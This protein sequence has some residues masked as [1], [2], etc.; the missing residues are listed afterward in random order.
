MCDT[1]ETQLVLKAA[2]GDRAALGQLLERYQ[3]RLY[4]V[5]LR[6]VYHRN[7]AAEVT[8]QVMLK[9]I[10]HIGAFGGKSRIST[11]MIRIAMNEAVSHLR[12]RKVRR[13]VSLDQPLAGTQ[14]AGEQGLSLGGQM[15]DEREPSPY[16]H[17]EN[18][19]MIEHL[20]KALYQLNDLF[21]TVLVLRDIDQM[22]YREIAGVLDIAVGTVKSR[23]FRARLALHK[24][25]GQ[26]AATHGR[27]D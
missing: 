22:D 5:V 19:E 15:I 2:G 12:R 17:V 11:W 1:D 4:N 25:M 20:H 6:I 21:T 13:T 14:S 9:V 24:R 27:D 23:L 7:D 18:N 3:D 8:Q 16:Q 10:E 26:L